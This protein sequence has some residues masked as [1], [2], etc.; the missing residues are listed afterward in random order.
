MN[1]SIIEVRVWD[2]LV[3]AVNLDSDYG[4]YAFGYAR[5]WKRKGIDLAP[6]L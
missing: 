5:S 4:Y 2:Q 1:T 6:C 3:G